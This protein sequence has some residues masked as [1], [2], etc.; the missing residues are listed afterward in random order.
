MEKANTSISPNGMG[1]LGLL[2]DHAILLHAPGE[3][4]PCLKWEES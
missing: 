4:Q 3:L 1:T 2:W